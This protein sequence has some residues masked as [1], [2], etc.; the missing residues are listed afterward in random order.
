MFKIAALNFLE[1]DELPV[2]KQTDPGYFGKGIYFTQ[3]GSS[4]AFGFP[5][6][7]LSQI[8][9]IRRSIR[10]GQGVSIVLVGDYGP[11]VPRDRVAYR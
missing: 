11:P 6:F 7:S 3:C 8:S 5:H 1:P 9:F 2:E 10:E 4:L